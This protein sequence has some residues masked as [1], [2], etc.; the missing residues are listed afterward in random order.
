MLAVTRARHEQGEAAIYSLREAARL[1]PGR[2]AVN[3]RWLIDQGLVSELDGKRLV[4]WAD[5]QE[6]IRQLREPRRRQNARRKL[7]RTERLGRVDLG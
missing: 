3:R 2:E 6:R 1:L 5:V 4:V 7:E